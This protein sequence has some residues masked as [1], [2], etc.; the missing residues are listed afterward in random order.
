MIKLGILLLFISSSFAETH[1]VVEGKNS[2]GDTARVFTCL[3][4]QSCGNTYFSTGSNNRI[5]I[6]TPQK[7]AE[8]KS[9]LEKCDLQLEKV[10]YIKNV[11]KDKKYISLTIDQNLEKTISLAPS[12]LNPTTREKQKEI[13]KRVKAAK[14]GQEIVDIVL[15]ELKFDFSDYTFDFNEKYDSEKKKGYAVTDHNNKLISFSD[16]KIYDPFG[17]IMMIRHEAEHIQQFKHTLKCNYS[18]SFLH[19]NNRERAAYLND[20]N[21]EE[22]WGYDSSGSFDQLDRYLSNANDS[23]EITKEGNIKHKF[24]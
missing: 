2:I 19:H 21:I 17:A 24:E 8:V 20:I 5:H 3:A 13:I 9:N 23:E 12:L 16:L 11:T 15:E 18:S 6:L 1:L 7:I 22:S 10:K 4:Y 14:D